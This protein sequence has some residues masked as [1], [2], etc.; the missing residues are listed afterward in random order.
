MRRP[1]DVSGG[2]A[3]R[4]A[5]ARAL[6]AEPSIVFADEPTG[7]LDSQS[8]QIVL[9][10]LRR[11]ADEGQMI[12]MVTHDLDAAA[13]ADLVAPDERAALAAALVVVARQPGVLDELG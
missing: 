7:A 2:Q 13:L 5:I 4:V 12:V 11:M 1:G 10:A 8:T 9:G 6:A 3:Q